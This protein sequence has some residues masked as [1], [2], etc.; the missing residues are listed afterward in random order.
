MTVT[1]QIPWKS[2]DVFPARPEGGEYGYMAGKKLVVSSREELIKKCGADQIPPVHLVWTPDTP[3]LAPPVEVPFLFDTIKLRAR[4]RFRLVIGS[5]LVNSVIWGTLGFIPVGHSKFSPIALLPAL[6]LGVMPIIQGCHGLWKLRSYSPEV[7]AGESD[8]VRYAAWVATRKVIFTNALLVCLGAV[9]IAQ[10]S[11]GLGHSV[12][13]AGLVKDAVWHGQ[14]WR[15]LTC[16]MLHGSWMHIFFNG[17]ALVQLG[18]TV[19]VLTHRAHLAI[20]FLIS[21]LAGSLCSLVFLPRLTS[22]GASG[23]LMGLI[24]FLAVLGYYHKH[25]LPPGFLRSIILS[26]VLIAAIGLFAHQFI[27]NAAHAGGLLAGIALGRVLINRTQLDFP[28][29]PSK[30]VVR[31]GWLAAVLILFTAAFS[32]YAIAR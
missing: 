31:L 21:A 11:N 14:V 9:W 13:D 26:I 29:S 4:K 18:R 17:T 24:G 32:I 28:S 23:G 6:F 10:L 7:M 15:L 2:K 22:V 25:S 3:N 27:D 8:T 19:E 16:A 5:G 30:S 12:D 20:V 1:R